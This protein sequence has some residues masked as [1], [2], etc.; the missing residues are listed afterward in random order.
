L[1]EPGKIIAHP[2]M[3]FEQAETLRLAGE[4]HFSRGR[5]EEAFVLLMRFCRLY[6][7]IVCQ[8]RLNPRKH[9]GSLDKMRGDY[10]ATVAKLDN[11]DMALQEKFSAS[12]ADAAEKPPSVVWS[13]SQDE[14]GDEPLASADSDASTDTADVAV[15]P[16]GEALLSRLRAALQDDAPSPPHR[17]ASSNSKVRSTSMSSDIHKHYPSAV[18]R[19][20]EPQTAPA[21]TWS[22]SSSLRSSLRKLK[23][24]SGRISSRLLGVAM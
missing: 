1:D 6:D 24:S 19:S 5:L 7:V 15:K 17:R 23:Q 2:S 18:R 8:S 10:A 9:M 21:N 12:D 4:V 13:T 11:I 3:L 14:S 20:M 16:Q 22:A